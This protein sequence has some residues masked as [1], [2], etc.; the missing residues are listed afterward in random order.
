MNTANTTFCIDEPELHMH[1]KLQGNL[2]EEIYSL[3]PENSQLWIATHSIGMMKKAKELYELAPESVVFLD[4][5]NRDFDDNV[6][7]EP[8]VISREFWKKILFTALDDLSQLIAPK[9]IVICEGKPEM[10]NSSKSEFDASCYR[11]IFSKKYSETDFISVGNADSVKNDKLFVGQTVQTISS[12]TDVVRVIDKDDRSQQEVEQLN[13]EGIKVL[14]RRN[15]ESYLLDDELLE[16]L[17]E[18]EGQLNK[19]YDLLNIKYQAISNSVNRGNPADDIKS[20]AG[21]IYNGIKRDLQ[22]TG[23]G[24][25]HA[26]FLRDTM[27]ELITPNTSVYSELEQDIFD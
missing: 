13:D 25:D 18:K 15:I 8:S 2:L 21:E 14:S 7:I 5:H 19:T 1:T 23:V 6:T 3:I 4:F 16:K 22:L 10:D 11:K 24:N 9:R 27:V 12:G 20:A 17:C 26:T